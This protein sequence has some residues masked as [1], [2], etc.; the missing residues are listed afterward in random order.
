M[1]GS[2]LRTV[3]LALAIAIG[4][5]SVQ[6]LNRAMLTTAH[7]GIACDYGQTLEVARRGW[8]DKGP[9][10]GNPILG[11]SPS[12]QRLTIYNATAAGAL[13]AIYL[14]TPERWRWFAPLVVTIAQLQVITMNT[15]SAPKPWCGL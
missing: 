2:M 7:A 9:A 15:I 11:S 3:T 5:C 4:G 6:T 13:T 1:M 14:A 8:P 10:E 12:P